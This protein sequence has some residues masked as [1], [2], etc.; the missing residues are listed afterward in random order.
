M[1]R[2]VSIEMK[3]V[4]ASIAKP[5]G[6]PTPGDKSLGIDTD[7]RLYEIEYSDNTEEG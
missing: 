7:I 4:K 3:I 1:A 2:S 6:K 5:N